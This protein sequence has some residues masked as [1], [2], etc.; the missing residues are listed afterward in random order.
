M[1]DSPLAYPVISHAFSPTFWQRK[2]RG[3]AFQT[4]TTRSRDSKAKASV[5]EEFRNERKYPEGSSMREAI[6]EPNHLQ[7]APT[8]VL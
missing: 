7:V 6:R 1:S 4:V 2:N 8:F 5:P 3:T